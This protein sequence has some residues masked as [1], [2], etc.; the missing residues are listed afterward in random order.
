MWS[1][2]KRVR[3]HE[4]QRCRGDNHKPHCRHLRPPALG[5]PALNKRALAQAARRAVERELSPG[6]SRVALGATPSINGGI[7]VHESTPLNSRP[8]YISTYSQ[9]L[10]VGHYPAGFEDVA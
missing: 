9:R 3:T 5:R 4:R 6:L 2:S 7:N 8:R 1:L 10:F